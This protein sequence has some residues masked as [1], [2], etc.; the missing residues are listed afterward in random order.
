MGNTWKTID[1]QVNWYRRRLAREW[2]NSDHYLFGRCKI[3]E[4]KWCIIYKHGTICEN[5]Q[6]HVTTASTVTTQITYTKLRDISLSET[7]FTAKGPCL[8]QT[9]AEGR[10][11]ELKELPLISSAGNSTSIPRLYS[12]RQPI[13]IFILDFSI[14]YSGRILRAPLEYPWECDNYIGTN[15]WTERHCKC[16]VFR[17][18]PTPCPETIGG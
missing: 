11:S 10:L 12:N 3:L 1:D 5:F 2:R 4:T 14:L 9:K 13:R 15:A 8:H 6:P 7:A 17:P 16:I 18:L